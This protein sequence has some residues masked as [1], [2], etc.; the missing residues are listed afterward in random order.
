MFINY[1]I[2]SKILN[3]FGWFRKISRK[4]SESRTILELFRSTLFIRA[5]NKFQDIKHFRVVLM[6]FKVITRMKDK[7]G[8]FFKNIF[9]RAT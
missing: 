4:Y 3:T 7:F 8:I 9:V 2:N 5:P 6:K 1:L